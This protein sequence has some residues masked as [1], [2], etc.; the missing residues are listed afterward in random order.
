MKKFTAVIILTVFFNAFTISAR[1][2]DETIKPGDIAAMGAIL[3]VAKTGRELWTKNERTPLAMAST[4]KIMTCILAIESGKIYDTVTVSKRAAMAPKVKMQLS[5][6]EKITLEYLLYALMLQSSN[7]AAVAIAEHIGGS[8]EKFCEQM[9]LKAREIGASNTVFETPNGLD[10]GDHHSTAYDLAVITRYALSN[11]YFMQLIN[12]E[13]IT[14]NSDK[15][16]YNVNNKNRLLRE[17]DGANGVKTGFTGKAGQCFVGAA[18][19]GD[20]QLI[21]VVL[22]SG[23]GERGKE[24][25]WKDTKKLLNYGFDNYKYET[26]IDAGED[27]GV[28]FIERSKTDKI[29]LRYAESVRQPLTADERDSVYIDAQFAN[30]MRAPVMK[31]QKVGT[32]K[33]FVKGQLF[34]EVDILANTSAERHDLKTSLEKIINELLQT[35]TN[36]NV[37][38]KLPE[39]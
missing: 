17:F 21:S 19:R 16:Q 30:L 22:A 11:E 9:T 23:W 36:E 5:A 4:T 33:I 29:S 12:T 31:D 24:Q 13:N 20:M 14:F 27:V 6:G 3:M 7:D 32:A 28:I 8:V 25:K 37:D 10:A 15:R 35:G 38:V 1:A 39:F 2:D 34:K 18:K 26:M